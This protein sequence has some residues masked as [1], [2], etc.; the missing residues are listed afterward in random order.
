ME[1][2]LFHLAWVNKCSIKV[3]KEIKEN[4]NELYNYSFINL[5]ICNFK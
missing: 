5:M 1:N 4:I 2:W 3:K